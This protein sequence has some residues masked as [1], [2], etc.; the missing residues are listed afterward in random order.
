MSDR[1]TGPASG[2]GRAQIAFPRTLLD[3]QRMFP[4]EQ[5]CADYLSRVRWPE[6]FTCPACTARGEPKRVRAIL[7]VRRPWVLAQSEDR[8]VSLTPRS[9]S[10]AG[11]AVE[12]R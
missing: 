11:G 2:V 9:H 8:S 6:G 3:F 7:F 4:D 5:A 12:V 10:R 1:P